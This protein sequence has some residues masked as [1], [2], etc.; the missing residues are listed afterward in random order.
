M[1]SGTLAV[2]QSYTRF[3]QSLKQ[4]ASELA[5][6]FLF[7]CFM[8]RS[9][10]VAMRVYVPEVFKIVQIKV[11]Q[12]HIFKVFFS[13]RRGFLLANITVYLPQTGSVFSST[14]LCPTFH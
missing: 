7:R 11:M 2:K 8:W 4:A 6:V 9:T 3:L 12:T 14:F 10:N 1:S 13:W 5:Q